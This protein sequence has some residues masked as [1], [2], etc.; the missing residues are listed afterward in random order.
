MKKAKMPKLNPILPKRGQR[1]VKAKKVRQQ[2]VG[3]IR[4]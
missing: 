4:G 2:A 1:A 3:G